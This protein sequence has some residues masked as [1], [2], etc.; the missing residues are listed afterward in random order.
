MGP[1]FVTFSSMSTAMLVRPSTRRAA[2]PSAT[3]GATRARPVSRLPSTS[4]KRGNG[5]VVPS[6]STATDA[7]T[8]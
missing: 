8:R 2:E 7:S 1:G 4:V 5:C 3:L 6:T